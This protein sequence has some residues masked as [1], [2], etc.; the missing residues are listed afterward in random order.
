VAFIFR[1]TRPPPTV[2]ND[3]SGSFGGFVGPDGGD[4]APQPIPGLRQIVD[5]YGARVWRALRFCGVPSSDLQNACEEVFLVVHR[6]IPEFD[7][8]SSLIAWLYRIC[9]QIAADRRRETHHRREQV[10]VDPPELP[11][12][13]T[14]P[15]GIDDSRTLERLLAILDGIK[16]SKREIFVLYEVEGLSMTEI[17]ETLGCPLRTA[18]SRLE[19]ARQEVMSAWQSED[20]GRRP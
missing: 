8:R 14:G 1:T 6:R 7:G 5:E 10:I 2:A 17:A 15:N 19:A 16:Q 4:A 13:P 11:V 9:V 3:P 18:H 20:L 12:P